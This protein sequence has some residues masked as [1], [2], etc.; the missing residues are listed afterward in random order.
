MNYTLLDNA[1]DFSTTIPNGTINKYIFSLECIFCKHPY[2]IALLQDG[3]FRKCLNPSC[4][5]NFQAKITNPPTSQSQIPSKLIMKHPNEF[6]MVK[7]KQLISQS[8]NKNIPDPIS[9]QETIPTS[10]SHP[11]YD[12]QIKYK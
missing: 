11:H 7:Q 6:H 5:K 9:F 3:S 2:S 12:P 10:F 1:F 8:N 4:K